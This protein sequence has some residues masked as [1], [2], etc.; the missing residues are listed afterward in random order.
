MGTKQAPSQ[1]DCY[2]KAEPD[3]PMFILLARDPLAA[4]LVKEWARL[5]AQQTGLTPK[6]IEAHKCAEDMNRW[7]EAQCI[8]PPTDK[9][10]LPNHEDTHLL[11]QLQQHLNQA[12]SGNLASLAILRKVA[13]ER[14]DIIETFKQKQNA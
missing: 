8:L 7:R 10:L 4:K 2:D 11:N 9:P 5:R 6:V 14:P 13:D 1:F 12:R 3:E